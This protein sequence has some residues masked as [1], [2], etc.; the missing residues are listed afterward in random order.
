MTAIIFSLL[1]GCGK[2][3]ETTS[4]STE[5][6]QTATISKDD[7]QII[8]VSNTDPKTGT[9]SIEIKAHVPDKQKTE[10]EDGTELN[11]ETTPDEKVE[12]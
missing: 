8:S 9:G 10:T 3:A 7:A 4:T 12:D 5:T 6:E 11:T 2:K 1:I